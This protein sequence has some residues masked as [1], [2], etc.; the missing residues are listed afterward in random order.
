MA[1]VTFTPNTKIVS[2]DV[3]A[4]FA[5]LAD[6]SLIAAGAIAL[7]KLTATA[8]S[9]FT[10]STTGFTGSPT[11]TGYYLQVG[12]IVFVYYSVSGTSNA[13][14][15]TFTLPVAAKRDARFVGAAAT[16]NGSAQT[17]TPY[18]GFAAS[19]TTCTT[20]KTLADGLWTNTNAKAISGSFFYESI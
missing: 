1:L 2:A 6:A 10:P 16:D 13:T 4:N 12:K 20:F 8:F 18:F 7:S 19:S 5:G 11:E 15:L 17:T 14:S 9:A 3:N